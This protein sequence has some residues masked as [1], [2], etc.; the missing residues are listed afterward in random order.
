MFSKQRIGRAK[1]VSE[2]DPN[3]YATNEAD[4][5]S[6]TCL[7]GTNFIEIAYTNLTEDLYPHSD[8]YKPIE[9]VPIVSGATAYDHPNVNIYIFIF[10]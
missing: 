6:Y 3:T 4:T 1:S 7:L 10:H 2:P 8:L 9:N 5:N